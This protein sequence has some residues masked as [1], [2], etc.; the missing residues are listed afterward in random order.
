M[1][2]RSEGPGSLGRAGPLRG[3]IGW[4]AMLP[5]TSRPCS[6]VAAST[7]RVE[8]RG[9]AGRQWQPSQPRAYGGPM[10]AQPRSCL[11]AEV[12][13]PRQLPF[14]QRQDPVNQAPTHG[15][16]RGTAAL[17]PDSPLPRQ[18][19]RVA[20]G[21]APDAR[22]SGLQSSAI[23]P[24]WYATPRPDLCKRRTYSVEGGVDVAAGASVPD[25]PANSRSV[26]LFKRT[27]RP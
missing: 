19:R 14:R 24:C 11:P 6:T 15:P 23:H 5:S 4:R 17:R 20:R 26:S 21:A 22:A 13:L 18:F 1:P 25:D 2:A 8:P 10:T 16:R 3:Q 7:I 12:A 27:H 9:A